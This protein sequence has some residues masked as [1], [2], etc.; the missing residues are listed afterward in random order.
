LDNSS[1]V[2][3]GIADSQIYLYGNVTQIEWQGDWF[4]SNVTRNYPIAMRDA[5]SS[6]LEDVELTL[7]DQDNTDIWNGF[8]DSLGTASFNVTFADSNRTDALML[9]TF[10][11]SFYN[12]TSNISLLSS[13]PIIINLTQKPLGDIN[14]DRTV[15][16]VDVAL[17]A[18]SFGCVP[19]DSKWNEL[20]D[21]NN[22]DTI[23]IV[24]ITLVAKDYGKTL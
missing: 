5:N 13:T 24:D 8:S 14:E 20:C 18:S 23:N 12:F 7:F 1:L 15:N 4:S 16:I 3:G 10:K 2:G 17:V 9:R 19:G 11:E 22:D 6:F 21:L